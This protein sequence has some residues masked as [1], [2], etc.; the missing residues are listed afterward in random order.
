MDFHN[1][2][3]KSIP[4]VLHDIDSLK[5]DWVDTK[6]QSVAVSKSRD[7]KLDLEEN[8]TKLQVTSKN[9]DSLNKLKPTSKIKT[10]KKRKRKRNPMTYKMCSKCPVQYKFIGR[11]KEHMKTKHNIDLFV[12]KVLVFL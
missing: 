10:D 5:R 11:L 7:K 1:E 3:T 4:S 8:V 6:L 2:M 9:E 12:C